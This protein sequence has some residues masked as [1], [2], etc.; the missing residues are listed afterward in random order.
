E[1]ALIGL[2]HPSL[3]SVPLHSSQ[4]TGSI[5]VTEDGAPFSFRFWGPVHE[6]IYAFYGIRN[7]I[8]QAFEPLLFGFAR[9]LAGPPGTEIRDLSLVLD[10]RLD[11]KVTVHVPPM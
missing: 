1:I 8:T 6:T 5:L 10:T 3:L 4:P 9:G 11:R 7:R 2:A